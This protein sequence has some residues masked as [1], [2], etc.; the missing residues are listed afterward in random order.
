MQAKG[1][2][3]MYVISKDRLSSACNHKEARTAKLVMT[4]SDSGPVLK[5]LETFQQMSGT[6]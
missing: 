4:D 3:K 6:S 1:M 5:S 2:S